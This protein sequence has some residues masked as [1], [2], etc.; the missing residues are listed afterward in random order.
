MKQ[1]SVWVTGLW[2]ALSV[3]L[4]GCG[5]ESGSVPERLAEEARAA[6]KPVASELVSTL[7][8]RLQA[9]M[10][11][12]GPEGGITVCA[13]EA[14]VLTEQVRMDSA[15]RY[16]KRVGVRIRNPENKPDRWEEA[17]L[18]H[19]LADGGGAGSYPVDW[20]QRVE[21][22]AGDTG[23]IRY[24][25]AIPMQARCLMC[26]GAAEDIP[27]SVRTV[28]DERYPGDRAR[29]FEEGEL[30]GLLVIGFDEEAL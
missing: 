11:S 12:G 15:I 6:G 2:A 21:D 23:E 25:R 30:R 24:Y 4:S 22:E 26:H 19:F 10:Q 7:E 9:A 5:G 14:Q 28:L 1:S 20:V 13:E 17:A 29:G 3:V 18:E 16:L 27:E 8:G